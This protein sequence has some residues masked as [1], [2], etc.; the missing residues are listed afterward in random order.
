MFTVG[1]IQ[2]NYF[3]MT[4][5]FMHFFYNRNLLLVKQVVMLVCV[6][7]IYLMSWCIIIGEEHLSI[8]FQY[9]GWVFDVDPY[10]A[11]KVGCYIH[12]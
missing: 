5:D 3:E 11:L 7:F 2:P 8:I 12:I 6:L 9:A 10:E 4:R 1:K